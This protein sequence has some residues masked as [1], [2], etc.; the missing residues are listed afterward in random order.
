M[1]TPLSVLFFLSGLLFSVFGAGKPFCVGRVGG[2]PG[3]KLL[4]GDSLMEGT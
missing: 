4:D 3:Q 2:R 1:L